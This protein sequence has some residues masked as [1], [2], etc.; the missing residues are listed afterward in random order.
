MTEIKDKVTTTD[1]FTLPY[2]IIKAK[3]QPTKG[4]IVYIHGGG[5]MF[6][7]ANDLSQQYIDIL[8]EQYDLVQLSYR[9]SPEVSLDCI[10]DDIFTSFDDIKLLYPNTPIFT[11]GRSSGAYLSLLIARNRDIDGVI[12][13]YGYSRI[14]TEPFKIQNDYYAKIARS[15]NESMVKQLTSPTPIIQDQIAQRFLIYVYARGTGEWMNMINVTDYT[16][17]KYNIASH[18][19]KTLPPVFIAHC[20][21]DYDVPIEESEHIMNHVPNTTFE[22]LSKN[23]HDFDR[24]PNDEAITVY[25]KVV[26][27]L[28][29][30][31]TK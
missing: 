17:S 15:V 29:T 10:I 11:F 23:E 30:I 26:A 18:E 1:A 27:F 14:D 31:I 12:D 4:A 2:T 20:I 16:D 8:T 13:F 24:R 3:K 5:L 6:G 7:N 22:R 9:L 28:N 19:L 25:H 21:G